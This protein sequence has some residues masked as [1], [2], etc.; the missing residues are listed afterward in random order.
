MN[1]GLRL[2]AE[3][4][5]PMDNVAPG[6][7]GLRILL[8]NVYGITAPGGSW[9]LVDAGLPFADERIR[10]WARITR[11][12]AAPACIVLTHGHFDHA[13]AVLELAGEWDVP[14]YAH[15][16]EMP[17]LTGQSSYPPPDPE[18]GGGMMSLLAPLYPKKPVDLGDRVRELPGDH[19]VPGLPGWRWI[20]TPGHTAGHI[21]LFRDEDRVLVA[22]DA[23]ITTKQE[24]A[25]AVATQRPELHGPPAYFTSDWDAARASVRELAALSPRVIAAGHG[26]PV[27]GEEAEVSLRSLAQH[28]DEW[29]R[30]SAGRY[31][32]QPA[33]TGPRGVVSLPP[34]RA[35]KAMPVILGAA[36][37]GV[38]WY[39]WSRRR[40]S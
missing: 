18:V 37:L 30:P 27:A 21:S 23:V 19:S 14:V 6:I 39:A 33:V 16:L 11:G 28:F 5:R 40:A 4:L 7:S 20:H 35:R 13:G 25:F 10:H 3:D 32:R 31:A 15:R 2:S 9:V 38:A 1:R 24:S 36:A 17:Y 26:L 8:V 34:A 22:G 29:A 12:A